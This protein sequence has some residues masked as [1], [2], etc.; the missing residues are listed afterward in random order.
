M[1]FK[2]IFLAALAIFMGVTLPLRS[3]PAGQE[4]VTPV[5][6]WSGSIEDLSLLKAAREF[7]L[8]AKEFENLWLAW[9]LPGSS[10]EVDFSSDLVAVQTTQG[11]RLRLSAALD[12]RG[13]LTVLGMATRDLRPG[14]RYVIAVLSRKRVR[15][16]NGKELSSTAGQN[17]PETSSAQDRADFGALAGVETHS[18]RSLDP[19]KINDEISQA[20]SKG[21]LWPKEAILVAL[22]FVGGGLKGNTKIIEVRTPPESQ[23]TATITVTESGYLD[24]AI[25]GEQW[26]LWLTKKADETWRTD[27]ALWAHLCSRPGHRFYSAGKCP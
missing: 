25:A 22:K 18:V 14:F 26:R 8:S 16:I 19:N 23:A 10:P 6:E 4:T 7:I 1:S 24:D 12:D 15:S 11:S 3:F 2:T 9:K 13:N 17:Y 5:R 21:E 20:F 27:R